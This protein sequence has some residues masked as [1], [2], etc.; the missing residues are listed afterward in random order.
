M[1]E[2]QTI[3]LERNAEWCEEFATEPCEVAWASEAI[4][5]I[6]A[7]EVD[8]IAPGS[9]ARIQLSPDGMNWCDEG[10][11]IRLPVEPGVAFCRVAHFGG[12]L[13]LSGRLPRGS[14]IKVIV[15]LT[16]KE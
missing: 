13:R 9:S 6:R 4:F 3:V 7:L 5:F 14:S 15:Y 8:G 11:S 16:L 12:W 2:S 1:R 10:E